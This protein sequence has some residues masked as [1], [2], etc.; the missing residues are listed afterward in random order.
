M[1]ICRNPNNPNVGYIISLSRNM[2]SAGPSERERL[3]KV[4]QN[5][6][7]TETQLRRKTELIGHLIARHFFA[8][9]KDGNLHEFDNYLFTEETLLKDEIIDIR[10]YFQIL[11]RA[12]RSPSEYLTRLKRL[13]KFLLMGRARQKFLCVVL[14]VI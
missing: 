8:I 5:M 12:P 6:L 14:V 4:I 11:G 2:L 3:R 13:L 9:P 1:T 7:D 10:K